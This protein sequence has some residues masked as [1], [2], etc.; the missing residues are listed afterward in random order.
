MTQEELIQSGFEKHVNDAVDKRFKLRWHNLLLLIAGVASVGGVSGWAWC[1]KTIQK[2]LERAQG[3]IID[4][5]NR[6]YQFTVL[7]NQVSVLQSNAS[8]ILDRARDA[9]GA[10]LKLE[11]SAMDTISSLASAQKEN[12]EHM[13]K[14][15]DEKTLRADSEFV[16]MRSKIDSLETNVAILD[17]DVSD[18]AAKIKEIGN[19]TTTI[20][21]NI[22]S[23]SILR[24]YL[25]EQITGQIITL[26]EDSEQIC[27]LPDPENASLTNTYLFALT[28]VGDV[29]NGSIRI[30][31]EKSLTRTAVT[32]VVRVPLSRNAEGFL[33][34]VGLELPIPETPFVVQPLY[35][36]LLGKRHRI[37]F[38][39]RPS[40]EKLRHL[41]QPE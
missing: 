7:S 23:S 14:D 32:K 19:Q 36:G 3:Q 25:E 34:Q 9:S 17:A 27:V 39:L 28:A 21:D 4:L 5:T 12:T 8:L 6:V 1:W 41:V 37:V 11:T 26:F 2:P 29:Q 24:T 35:F 13:L 40:S 18:K 22:R 30:T 31:C 38:R 15:Y 33:Q 10:A 20:R 16:K